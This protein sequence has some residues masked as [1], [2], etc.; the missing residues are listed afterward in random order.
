MLPRYALDNVSLKSHA[1]I[2]EHS[3]QHIW[4]PAQSLWIGLLAMSINAAWRNI[5]RAVKMVKEAGRDTNHCNW[6]GTGNNTLNARGKRERYKEQRDY[7]S[8]KPRHSVQRFIS[9]INEV[10][11]YISF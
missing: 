11:P 6:K 5:N 3:P 4:G 9:F 8:G 7:N 2:R 10:T 1:G